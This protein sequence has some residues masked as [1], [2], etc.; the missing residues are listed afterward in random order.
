MFTCM[1]R[2]ETCWRHW[3]CSRFWP[4]VED[5]CRAAPVGGANF[6]EEYLAPVF[7]TAPETPAA[8]AEASVGAIELLQALLEHL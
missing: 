2:R 5:G 1:N 4:L 8:A 7:S 6:F 3:S